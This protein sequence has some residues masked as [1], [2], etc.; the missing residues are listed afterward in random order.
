VR[1][2]GHLFMFEP[3]HPGNRPPKMLREYLPSGKRVSDTPI[4]WKVSDVA[5]GPKFDPAGNIYVA[6]QVKPAGRPPYPQEFVSV[7]GKANVRSQTSRM[8]G[9]ILKFSSKGGMVDW[10][11]TA[12]GACRENPFKGQPKLAP[13]LKTVA[14]AGGARVTGAEWM[15]FGISH[16]EFISCNCESTRFDVDEF[17]RVWYP[18]LGRFR[19]CVL[20]TAGNPITHFGG[21]GNTENRGPES[22]EPSLKKPDLAFAWLA[23]VGITD[24]YAYMGDSMNKRLLRARLVCATEEVCSIQ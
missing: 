23:G 10:P 6:E 22:T 13:G 16:I 12:N 24:K 18:D 14:C 17:G 19:I 1:G 15:H 9:S 3:G 4:I 2:D 11:G 21:F 20:D 7:L 5:V 8:Y